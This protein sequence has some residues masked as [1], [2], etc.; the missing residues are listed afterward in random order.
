MMWSLSFILSTIGS[1]WRV[2]RGVLWFASKII[3]VA[4]WR[5]D[6]GRVRD[7]QRDYC[8]HS[9]W[10]WQCLGVGHG[11]WRWKEVEG[12]QP[13]FGLPAHPV[14][15]VGKTRGEQKGEIK[16]DSEV[17]YSISKGPDSI[18]YWV[19]W[20]WGGASLEEKSQ[21]LYFVMLSLRHLLEPQVG[22]RGR[23]WIYQLGAQVRGQ[24]WGYIWKY[25]CEE[26][27]KSRGFEKSI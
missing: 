27:W 19:R 13:M 17:F 16:S 21:E 18:I 6:G 5:M 24:S 8:P 15:F 3:M 11:L 25:L 10:E 9:G 7:G 4:L 20:L 12:F 26:S 14:H 2:Y 23:Q 1:Y 22:K